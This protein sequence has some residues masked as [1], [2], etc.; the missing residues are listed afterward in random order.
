[1]RWGPGQTE[2]GQSADVEG[3]EAGGWLALAFGVAVERNANA[4]RMAVC[5]CLSEGRRLKSA[6]GRRME[7]NQREYSYLGALVSPMEDCGCL[8]CE[9]LVWF[10]SRSR[11]Q[12]IR[13]AQRAGPG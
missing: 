10:L 6:K 8:G 13:Q 3:V 1:M 7:G 2:I 5:Q 12:P 11:Q 4:P 9:S